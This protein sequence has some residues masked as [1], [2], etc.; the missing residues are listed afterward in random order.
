MTFAFLTCDSSYVYRINDQC[1]ADQHLGLNAHSLDDVSIKAWFQ[2]LK[3]SLAPSVCSTGYW[4]V[5]VPLPSLLTGQS[6][7]SSI[8]LS[9]L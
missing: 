8:I 2:L 5:R 7:P 9:N 3:S 6:I 1:D 4:I